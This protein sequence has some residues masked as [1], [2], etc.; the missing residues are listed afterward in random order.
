MDKAGVTTVQTSQKILCDTGR[1]SVGG[2]T[3]TERGHLVIP[4]R[5]INAA[6]NTVLPLLIFSRVKYHRKFI[7]GVP[8]GSIGEA[9]KSGWINENIFILYLEHLCAITDVLSKKGSAIIG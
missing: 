4:A 8:V 6:G 9:N 7:N 2:V 3:L 1:R 5:T